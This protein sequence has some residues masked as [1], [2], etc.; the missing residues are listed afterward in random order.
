MTPGTV[1]LLA[2]AVILG[3]IAWATVTSDRRVRQRAILR[4]QRALEGV[5][6]GE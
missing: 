5:R 2:L 3:R 4:A 6:D 1:F